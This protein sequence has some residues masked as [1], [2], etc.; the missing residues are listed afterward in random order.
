MT[1][2]KNKVQIMLQMQHDLNVLLAN[3]WINR[4]LPYYRAVW[5]EAAELIEH[6]GWKWWKHQSEDT[7]QMQMEVV[8]IWH[9]LLSMYITHTST[10]DI[11]VEQLLDLLEPI[12]DKCTMTAQEDISDTILPVTEDLVLNTLLYNKTLYT[13]QLQE[14][15][16]SFFLLLLATGLNIDILFERYIGKNLLNE[17]RKT[18]GYKEGTYIKVWNGREDNEYLHEILMRTEISVE[19][20]KEIKYNILS[21]LNTTYESLLNEHTTSTISE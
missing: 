16:N 12:Y 7:P 10:N 3:D 9:F 21:E 14:L 6:K 19:N 18:H 20:F 8:D 11:V 2:F 17:F 4:K 5:V 15:S 1:N 13:S